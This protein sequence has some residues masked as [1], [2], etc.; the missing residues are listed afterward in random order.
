MSESWKLSLDTLTTPLNATSFSPLRKT[1]ENFLFPASPTLLKTLGIDN[2]KYLSYRNYLINCKSKTQKKEYKG[3]LRQYQLEDVHFLSHHNKAA[4]FNQ[5]RTGKTPT[6]LSRI[7]LAPDISRVL[8][9]APKSTLFQW[10]NEIQKWTSLKNIEVVR[11]TPEKRTEIY[12]KHTTH[13]V[14]F[15]L[16][17]IDFDLLKTFHYDCVILDEAHRIK[18]FKSYA[19]KKR[20]KTTDDTIV[21]VDTQITAKSI[22][23]LAHKCKYRFALTGTPTTNKSSEIYPILHFLFPDLFSSYY[24][25]IDYYYYVAI[26]EFNGNRIKSPIQFLS[27]D[28][29]MELLEFLQLFS[30][31]RKRNEVMNFLQK[32]EEETI[33]LPMSPQQKLNYDKLNQTLEL[34]DVIVT[35]GLELMTR[36]RQLTVS[37]LL[38]DS[39]DIGCKIEHILEYIKDYPNEN[40]FI[41]SMFAQFVK[42][43]QK[44]LNQ[45]KSAIITGDT[46]STKRTEI[47]NR[48]QNGSLKILVAQLDTVKEG[49]Q[50]DNADTMFFVDFSLTYTDNEQCKDRIVPISKERALLKEQKI[51]FLLAENSIDEYLYDQVMVHKKNATSII[52]NYVQTIKER[53][54]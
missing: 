10:K 16:C 41:V 4:I 32:I 49:I 35:S 14:N 17:H 29:E 21:K 5:Q 40:I 11:G 34:N 7:N 31:Q 45:K 2:P 43:L 18:N 9:I 6:I 53:R 33:K 50:L 22:M 19:S 39:K 46:P 15:E 20:K 30:I 48:F 27:K 42:Q 52:N 47:F 54:N 38:L 28:K 26:E 8:I 37:P 23:R 25:F 1:K 13:I 36:Q 3:P 12:K 51:F 24:Q 44:L